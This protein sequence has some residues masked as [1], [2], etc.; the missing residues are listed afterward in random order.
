MK[1]NTSSFFHWVATSQGGNKCGSRDVYT[2]C[3]RAPVDSTIESAM[4]FG[5]SYIGDLEERSR[6]EGSKTCDAE[7]ALQTVQ[8][9]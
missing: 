2:A 3:A 4:Q 8:L 5:K 1:R 6:W 9:V 7:L